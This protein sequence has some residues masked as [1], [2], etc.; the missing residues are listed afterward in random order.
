MTLIQ[1]LVKRGI[2]GKEKATSLEFELKSSEKT[3]EELILE[4]EIVPETFLFTLKSESLKIPLK[5]IPGE[6]VPLGVLELI[7]EDAAKYYKMIPLAKVNKKVE[8]GMVYPENLK[9]Q[10]ALKFIG[11]RAKFSPKIVL[12]SLTTLNNLL[13]QYKTLRGEVKRALTELEGELKGEKTETGPFEAPEFE[14]LVA[15]APISKVVAVILRHAVEGEASDVHIEP[16]KE[17]LRIRFRLDGILHSSIFLPL[18]IHPAVV[19]RVKILSN[20]KI[21]ETRKPQDGRFSTKIDGNDIDFRVATFPT[22]LGEKVAIRVLDPTRGLT[23]F[24]QL[25][26]EGRN[27]KVIK[28]ALKKPFGL[29]LTTGPTGCGKSTT[30]YA[31]LRILNKEEVNIVTLEDPVEYSIRG[32]N[33]S[34][35]RPEIGYDFAQGLRQIVRQDPDIIMVGEIR[36]E[37]TAALATHAAL[38]GHI[39]LSTLH[40]TNALGAIPRLIDLGV[41]P[42][43]ISPTLNIVLAQRLVRRLCPHCK[44]KIKPPKEIEDVILKEIQNLSPATK[45]KLKIPHPLY[46]YQSSGCQKCLNKGYKGRTALYEVL[47]MTNK[48][49]EIVLKEPSEA[50]ITEEANRQEM[51]TMRQDGILK[52]LRGITSVEEVIKVAEET[53]I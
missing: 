47:E 53:Q 4:K 5:K 21:D 37:E 26:L 40:T 30:L 13:K 18:R 45:K 3:E 43:L 16:T 23:T 2:L 29:I 35:V 44:K 22:T 8:I 10:E 20:L 6:E 15:E 27:L 42:F 11:R 49:A 48:L 25:G 12:I 1:Q 7:P 36:D 9:V 33:Q 19:A 34:Q 38:T 28:N 51:I 50:K 41:R 46:I 17:K 39:V 14:K 24:E 32:V 52:V 31:M